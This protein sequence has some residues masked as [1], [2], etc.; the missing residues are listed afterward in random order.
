MIT[1]PNCKNEKE[2]EKEYMSSESSRK[3]NYI[4]S[5][6]LEMHLI[7]RHLT[8]SVWFKNILFIC[9]VW[10]MKG[11]LTYFLNIR[12]LFYYEHDKLP[13]LVIL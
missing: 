5:D 9:D 1:G 3:F 4:L 6:L 10:I 2:E 7:Y 12:V 8:Q 13:D 11:H